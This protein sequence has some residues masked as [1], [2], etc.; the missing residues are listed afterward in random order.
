MNGHYLRHLRPEIF[1]N[2]CKPALR[3]AGLISGETDSAHLATVLGACQEKIRDVESLP[4][5]C[6]PFFTDDFPFDEAAR[7]KIFKQG[8][9]SAR[10]REFLDALPSSVDFAGENL[11][12]LVGTLSQTHGCKTGDYIHPIRFAV[13]GQSVGIGFYQLL[14]ILGK[15]WVISRLEKFIQGV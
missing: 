3:S 4:N 12:V 14:H 2:F 6:A 5:F 8:N 15:E 11:E 1:A 7:E 13:S 10:I 9:P